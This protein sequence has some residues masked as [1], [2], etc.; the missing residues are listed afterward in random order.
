MGSWV[1][2]IKSVQPGRQ[3]HVSALYAQPVMAHTWER[4]VHRQADRP[5]NSQ[6]VAVHLATVEALTG[7]TGGV[8]TMVGPTGGVEVVVDLVECV[9]QWAVLVG[10]MRWLSVGIPPAARQLGEEMLAWV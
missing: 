7:A 5:L 6:S 8:V 2:I 3:S 1:I 10:V 4:T 9:G